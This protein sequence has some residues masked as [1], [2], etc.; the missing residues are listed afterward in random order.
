[1]LREG[2]PHHAAGE[3]ADKEAENGHGVKRAGERRREQRD[4]NTGDGHQVRLQSKRIASS[5]T[6]FLPKLSEHCPNRIDPTITPIICIVM[7]SF[8]SFCL[9]QIQSN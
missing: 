8:T 4:Y 2:R 3:Q 6:F 9:S 7:L 5:S 1:M